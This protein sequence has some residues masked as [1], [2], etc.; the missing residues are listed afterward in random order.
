MENKTGEYIVKVWVSTRWVPYLELW[1]WA[2]K[3]LQLVSS[4]STIAYRQPVFRYHKVIELVP[5]DSQE[6]ENKDFGVS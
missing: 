3:E 1:F 6:S 2:R 5:S 4:K